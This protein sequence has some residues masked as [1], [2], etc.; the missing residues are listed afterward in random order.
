MYA[1]V[2]IATVYIILLYV[3]S[4]PLYWLSYTGGWHE[5]GLHVPPAAEPG[6]RTAMRA[7]TRTHSI[8]RYLVAASPNRPA[9]DGER[10]S[11]PRTCRRP[12]AYA[13]PASKST[14]T[15]L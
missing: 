14:A 7:T 2:V 13:G 10:G 12:L 6:Q 15:P 3:S 9:N 1:D 11:P 4:K 5:L 8:P